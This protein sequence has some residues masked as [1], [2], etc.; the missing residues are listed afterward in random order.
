MSSYIHGTTDEK[1][2]ARLEKQAQFAAPFILQDFVAYPGERV[3]D[4]ATGVGAMA[5]QLLQRFP[6]IRLVGVDLRRTQLL[7]ATKNHPG[8]AWVNADGSALPFADGAFDRV[9][10]SWLLEHVPEPVK[11]LAEVRRVLRPGGSCQFIEVENSTFRTVP[12]DPEVLEVMDALN[13]AQQAGGGDPFVGR[14][15]GEYLAAA[16]FEQVKLT[17]APLEGSSEDLERFIG[18][19]EEFAEIFESIDESVDPQMGQRAR[20]AADKIRAL[21]RLPGAQMHYAGVLAQGVRGA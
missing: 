18:F 7:M 4:L 16:G 11:I 1:E 5:G 12:E 19:A 15:L 9:H 8:P 2:T 6:G 10:C 20:R 17:P 3:L 13:R 14:H 21:P